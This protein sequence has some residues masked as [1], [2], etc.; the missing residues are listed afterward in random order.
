[1]SNRKFTT[2]SRVIRD[3][4]AQYS[5]TFACL[6]ELLNN[7]IQANAKNIQIRIDYTPSHA[8]SDLPITKITVRD[9]GHGVAISKLEKTL[10]DIGAESK[11]GGKGVGRFAALQIG[12]S[13][14]IDT[15]A[16]DDDKKSFSVLSIPING[17]DLESVKTI[18]D[19]DL[20]VKEL[21]L[22]G[23]HTPYYSVEI[24]DLYDK[25][26]VEK[27][28]KRKLVKQ[29]L[30]ENIFKALFE[31]Y[32]SLIFQR[33]ISIS[34]NDVVLN[35]SD[36]V[37]KQPVIKP[38]VY[39]DK[40][41]N[42]HNIQFTYYELR[43]DIQAEGIKIFLTVDNAGIESVA[44]EFEFNA[45]WLSPDVGDWFVYIKSDF[46]TTDMLRNLDFKLNDQNRALR[47][48]I[49]E[50]LTEFFKEQSLAYLSFKDKLSVDKDYQ[51]IKKNFAS[52]SKNIVFDNIAYFIET[53]HRLLAT[54]NELKSIIYPLIDKAISNGDLVD[55]LKE[56]IKLDDESL[57]KINHLVKDVRLEDVIDF[58]EKVAKKQRQAEF[59]EEITVSDI[60]N[61]ILERS[62]LHKYL[63]D[64]LWLF[65]EQYLEST[66]LLSDKSLEKNLKKLRDDYLTYEED[67]KNADNVEKVDEQVRSITDLFFYSEKPIDSERREVLIVELKAPKVRLS[68]KELEQ[69]MTY[70]F[71]IENSKFYSAKINYKIILVGSSINKR[72]LSTIK[73]NSKNKPNHPYFYWEN[74]Q[75]NILVEVMKWPDL[76]ENTK[77]KLNYLAN[78]IKLKDKSIATSVT[79]EFENI[80]HAKLKS[81]LTRSK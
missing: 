45:D 79:E 25:V 67:Q 69:V 9:D 30:L 65:G 47:T 55:F 28:P 38:E 14:K 4:F 18:N 16:Y 71:E 61:N 59:I 15:V 37:D 33:K 75:G 74:E 43:K 34:I 44:S 35:P 77:R 80:E 42:K 36:F 20:D 49:R 62:Q 76:I 63:E 66:S 31:V 23:S 19:L 13:I 57:K 7:S 51:T 29:F 39:E 24:S 60:S 53:R 17:K 73:G 26:I 78:K 11:D 5:D 64:K 48:F 46:F 56:V 22:E 41:G 1:M 3:L 52:Q 40:F 68:N 2:N 8:M 21:Y 70:A 32:P 58:A 50:K 54:G 12:N 27:F 10:L 72:A 81:T 6:I